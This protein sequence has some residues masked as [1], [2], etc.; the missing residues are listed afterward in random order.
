MGSTGKEISGVTGAVNDAGI[1]NIIG[2]QGET[3]IGGP[4]PLCCVCRN[5]HMAHIY[6]DLNLRENGPPIVRVCPGCLIKTKKLLKNIE[7][8]K[9]I[10]LPL[11]INHENIFV[12]EA[13]KN[14]L[15]GK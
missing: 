7:K 15:S 8:M 13:I 2:M 6:C 5:F 11:Q 1:P 9:V 14:R 12:R 10:E 4:L 3:S